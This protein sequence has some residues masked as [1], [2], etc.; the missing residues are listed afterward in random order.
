MGDPVTS[1]VADLALSLGGFCAGFI[2]CAI[3][4]SAQGVQIDFKAPFRRRSGEQKEDRAERRR[5]KA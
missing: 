4:A 5:A 1:I 3:Y 2:F